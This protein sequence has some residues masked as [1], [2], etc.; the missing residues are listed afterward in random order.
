MLE[1]QVS[2]G[3][4]QIKILQSM[5]ASEQSKNTVLAE[6]LSKKSKD[7]NDEKNLKNIKKVKSY[8]SSGETDEERGRKFLNE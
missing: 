1:N 7:E 4:K 3:Q 8:E 5:L 6:S 2:D